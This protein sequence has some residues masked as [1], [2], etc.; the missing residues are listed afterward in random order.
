LATADRRKSKATVVANVNK[1]ISE[2]SPS[3][4]TQ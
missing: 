2:M 4:M 1:V 3:E